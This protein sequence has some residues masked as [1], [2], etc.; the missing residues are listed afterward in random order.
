MTQPPP[1][2][3]QARSAHVV[4]VR[5]LTPRRRRVVLGVDDPADLRI[6][7]YTDQYIRLLIAPRGMTYTQP[8]DLEHI[9]ATQP[10]ELW[11]RLRSYTIRAWDPDSG[12]ITVDF[13]MHGHNGLATEWARRVEPGE[14]VHFMEPRGA[15]YP[16][17]SADWH[18]LVGDESALSAVAAGVEAL[19]KGA[20]ATVLLEVDDPLE[21][22]RIDAPA[23]ADIAWLHRGA[24]RV[25]ARL[26]DAV[27]NLRLPSDGLQA[28]VHGE[29]SFVREIRRHLLL[30]RDVPREDVSAS[31]YWRLDHTDEHWRASKPAWNA[32]IAAEEERLV[33][34][35]LSPQR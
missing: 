35:A 17:P 9:K 5:Q 18:L 27:H 15:Y 11:P 28:F 30:D 31:G 6:G 32:Q 25:G 12:E 7:P 26:L 22:Q 13:T 4:H 3:P 23:G 1:R 2:R 21:E 34:T 16:Q 24:D 14:I 33:E 19:P 8:F 29:A 10:G 20:R